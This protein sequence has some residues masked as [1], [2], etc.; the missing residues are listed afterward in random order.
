MRYLKG[1][2]RST[3]RNFERGFE[4]VEICEFVI[5]RLGCG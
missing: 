3:F 4:E 2:G 5:I 1:K